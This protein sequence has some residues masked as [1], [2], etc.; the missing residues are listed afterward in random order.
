M[1]LTYLK[2]NV[3]I[4]E[5]IKQYYDVLPAFYI[6][7]AIQTYQRWLEAAEPGD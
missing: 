1:I 2:G 7:S 3:E 6:P 5:K 4:S